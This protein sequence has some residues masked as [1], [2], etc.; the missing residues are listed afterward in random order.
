[1]LI[2]I[3]QVF[4]AI[5]IDTFGDMRNEKN[6]IEELVNSTCLICGKE[7]DE[8]E[9]DGEDFTKHVKVRVSDGQFRHNMFNYILFIAYL[10]KKNPIDYTGI[11]SYVY[12]SYNS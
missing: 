5:L 4:A 9:R 11:E 8:I 2:L 3:T 12:Q 6:K 7:R 10:K 1:M